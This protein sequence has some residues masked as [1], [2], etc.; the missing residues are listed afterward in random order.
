MLEYRSLRMSTS[1]FM[2]VWKAVSWMPL[3]S[4][5]MNDGWNSTSGN[6]NRSLPAVV[7]K[8][9]PRSVKIFIMYSVKSRP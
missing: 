2:M 1:H 8:L 6:R 3:A 7:V 5:P 4:F 9:Y